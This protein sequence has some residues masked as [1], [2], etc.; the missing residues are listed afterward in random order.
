MIDDVIPLLV[1][2]GKITNL[3]AE[4]RTSSNSLRGLFEGDE[5]R[6]KVKAIFVTCDRESLVNIVLHADDLFENIFYLEDE[7]AEIWYVVNGWHHFQMSQMFRYREG[8]VL[9]FVTTIFTETAVTGSIYIIGAKYLNLAMD[10]EKNHH[11][12]DTWVGTKHAERLY[13]HGLVPSSIE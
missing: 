2:A 10:Y 7:L 12:L 8:T 6:Y 9:R 3:G 11:K 5:S 4:I 1:S 13:A